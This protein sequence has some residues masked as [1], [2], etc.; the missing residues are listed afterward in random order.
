DTQDAVKLC[1]WDNRLWAIDANGLMSQSANGG[2]DSWTA[3]AE[4]SGVDGTYRFI[5]SLFVAKKSD[6]T[7]A[8]YCTTN[9]GLWRHN[10]TSTKWEGPLLTWPRHP[11]GGRGT[12]EARGEA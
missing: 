11:H 5:T 9:D 3:D 2:A 8:I 7:T 4:L 10:A 12:I 1:V 6:G